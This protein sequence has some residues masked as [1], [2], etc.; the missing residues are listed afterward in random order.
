MV[1]IRIRNGFADRKK[2]NSVGTE[3]QVNSISSQSRTIIKN[4]IIDLLQRW[5][6]EFV[7]SDFEN[8]FSKLMSNEV[9]CLPL[10]SGVSSYNSVL[11]L[12]WN[13]I[14]E[15][16]YFDVL[17]IIEFLGNSI[18]ITR[19]DGFLSWN[20]N[21]SEVDIKAE[22]NKLFERECIG[23]RFINNYI[24]QITSDTEIKEITKA[25][26]SPFEDKVNLHIKKAL[27]SLSATKG[28]DYPNS[29]KESI[30]AIEGF[31]SLVVKKPGTL[32]DH[33]KEI[34]NKHHLHPAFGKML[35]ELYG[36]SSDESG[37]RHENIKKG[38]STTFD[39]AKYILVLCCSTVNYL[40]GVCAKDIK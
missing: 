37:I 16:E 34:V 27:E 4:K 13:S 25:V 21:I 6:R 30:L 10:D 31:C 19:Y 38:H 11:N 33:I 29:I 17:S 28:R 9:F 3:I 1:E 22:F 7:Y 32:G 26:N 40:M 5:K 2:L 39:E 35:L 8:Y 24:E 36:Y 14:D 12:L 20:P 23:Y 15:A 18:H